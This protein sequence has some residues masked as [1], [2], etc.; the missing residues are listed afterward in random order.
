MSHSHHH[1]HH[2]DTESTLSF[3]E[4]LE[5][6]LD[7]WIRHNEEHQDTYQK[8]A[9]RSMENQL[10]EVAAVLEEA[11]NLT[12]SINHKLRAAAGFLKNRDK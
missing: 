10:N 8:W 2:H 12:E 5:K 9:E 11:G 6:L 7:H 4:K 3:E 1:H